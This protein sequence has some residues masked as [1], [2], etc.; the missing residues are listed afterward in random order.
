VASGKKP[1][2]AKPPEQVRDS[3]AELLNIYARRA[4]REGDPFRYSPQDYEGVCQRLCFSETADQNAAIHAVIQAHD[5][6]SPAC[7]PLGVRRMW[8]LAKPKWRC[9]PRLW[10]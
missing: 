3:A 8:A 5:Q 6:P 7:V 9:V 4:A 1:Q 10:R 2:T